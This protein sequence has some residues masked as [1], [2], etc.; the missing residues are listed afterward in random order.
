MITKWWKFQK[1]CFNLKTVSF[2]VPWV[3]NSRENKI[4]CLTPGRREESFN[5]PPP[6]IPPSPGN[7]HVGIWTL[8]IDFFKFLLLL[9][10]N[11]WSNGSF[12]AFVKGKICNLIDFSI[13]TYLLAKVKYY[14]LDVWSQGKQLVLFPDVPSTLSRETPGL[15]VKQN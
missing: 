6:N 15:V 13:L 11:S 2:V 4:I 9:E 1:F 8:K 14:T 3:L 12:N 5:I 10:K 7:P